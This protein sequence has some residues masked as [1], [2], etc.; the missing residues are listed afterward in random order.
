MAERGNDPETTN[1]FDPH[2]GDD[3]DDTTPLVPHDKGGGIEMKRPFHKFPPLPRTKTSTS[4]SGEQETSFIDTHS[5]E[6]HT[7]NKEEIE[8][9]D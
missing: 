2:G 7:S 5:G 1:P 4:T 3:D 6:V 9:K 8:K